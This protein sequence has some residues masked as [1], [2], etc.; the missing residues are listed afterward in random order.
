M[1]PPTLSFFFFLSVCSYCMW[2]VLVC[3]PDWYRMEHFDRFSLPLAY[4]ILMNINPSLH[5]A[6]LFLLIPEGDTLTMSAFPRQWAF[7]LLKP[8]HAQV[9]SWEEETAP[10][11]LPSLTAVFL[12]L[13]E[14]STLNSQRVS[15]N[16]QSPAE[17]EA[18]LAI[19]PNSVLIT[20]DSTKH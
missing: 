18:K 14:T 3:R 17:A 16:H 13:K 9:A 12:H 8:T 6:S 10:A 19:A 2:L 11:K 4:G 20:R 5:E 7:S 15:P 1:K